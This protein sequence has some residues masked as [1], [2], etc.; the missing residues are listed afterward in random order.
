MDEENQNN[1]NLQIKRE[2]TNARVKKYRKK[3]CT[4]SQ[5]LNFSMQDAPSEEMQNK[6][7]KENNAERKRAMEKER[8][9]RFREKKRLNILKSVHH[10][11]SLFS[12]L[13]CDLKH[14]QFF[15]LF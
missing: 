14:T 8:S 3:K 12:I 1:D 6:R 9:R 15:F 2:L 4:E 5:Q 13:P 11:V 10:V 7:V